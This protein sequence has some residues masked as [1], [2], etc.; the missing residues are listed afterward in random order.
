MEAEEPIAPYHFDE[1]KSLA[2]AQ[3]TDFHYH[4]VVQYLRLSRRAMGL[5]GVELISA[6]PGSRLNA[7]F[8][9]Q[10]VSELLAELGEEIG[11]PAR[12][13]TRG[14]YGRRYEAERQPA[15]PMKDF[16][17]HN[18]PVESRGTP[19]PAAPSSKSAGSMSGAARLRAALDELPEIEVPLVEEA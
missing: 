17:P 15:C 6:T 9:Y 18:W 5:A 2:A 4:R 13:T 16:R 10:P 3:Q 14:Q 12:E 1:T 11:N 7:F 19:V 8:P